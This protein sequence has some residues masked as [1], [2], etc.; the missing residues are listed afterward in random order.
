MTDITPDARVCANCSFSWL[1]TQNS[2]LYCRR[3]PPTNFIIGSTSIVGQAPQPITQA[4]FPNT[5]PDTWCGE[6]RRKLTA[7]P[8]PTETP[9]D[10]VA[11]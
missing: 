1:W 10:P 8:S 2:G 7:V 3:Y 9:N 5:T 11:A 4:Y 6:F